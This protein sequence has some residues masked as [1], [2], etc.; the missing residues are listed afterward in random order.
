[1]VRSFN[2]YFLN[3]KDSQEPVHVSEIDQVM[4]LQ[5][6]TILLCY[7]WIRKYL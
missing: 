3:S 2:L 4:K 5:I 7:E 6:S 1:M